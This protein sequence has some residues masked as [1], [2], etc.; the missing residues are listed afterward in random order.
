[1][2]GR[3]AAIAIGLVAATAAMAC[4]APAR[5]ATRIQPVE[6]LREE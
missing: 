2:N 1:M 4:L 6:A 5:R 3:H